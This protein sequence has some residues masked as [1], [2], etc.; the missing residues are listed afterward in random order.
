MRT[1]SQPPET[2]DAIT[3]SYSHRKPI[4]QLP[5]QPRGIGRVPSLG[6]VRDALAPIFAPSSRPLA[7]PVQ[8]RRPTSLCRRFAGNLTADDQVVGACK[9]DCSSLLWMTSPGSRAPGASRDSSY[10]VVHGEV[11]IPPWPRPA[12]HRHGEPRP[13]CPAGGLAEQF[14]GAAGPGE[15]LHGLAVQSGDAADR[16]Q[17]FAGVQPPVDLGVAF[18]GA[19]HQAA[20]PAARVQGPVQRDL[21]ACSLPQ[22]FL[23]QRVRRTQRVVAVVA[24][25]WSFRQPRWP[26]TV[27]SAYSARLCHRC[28][29]SATWIA[30][31]APARAP[32]A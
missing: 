28:Q 13:P 26:A 18:P 25:G 11:L 4:S 20:L 23:L 19:C 17:R 5:G 12:D 24:A 29:R 14:P 15:P 31:G 9:A 10:H 1:D 21:R 27:F 30:S 8:D 7:A 16:G 6:I 32:S 22:R 2:P 3:G